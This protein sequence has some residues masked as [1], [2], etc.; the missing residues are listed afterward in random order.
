MRITAISPHVNQAARGG[1]SGPDA[2]RRRRTG[3]ATISLRFDTHVLARIDTAAKRLGIS[4][5]SFW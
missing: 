4:A 5:T 1:G 3:I 2:T